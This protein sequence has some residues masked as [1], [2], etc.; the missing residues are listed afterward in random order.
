MEPTLKVGSHIT[1]DTTRRTPAI[2]AIIVFHPPVG[3]NPGLPVCGDRQGGVGH[4]RA[5]AMPTPGESAQVFVKRVVAVGGDTISIVN[6]HV[7]RD[8]VHQPDAYIRP[9]GG[10]PLCNFPQPVTIP[11]G[12]Y[13]VLGDN[14]GES[15]DSR[16]WGPVLRAWIIGTVVSHS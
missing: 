6:G 12:H 4:A 14:R 9:C 5:C 16:F 10:G 2:G 3:A 13:F 11:P 1:V 8:G 15:D 7:I